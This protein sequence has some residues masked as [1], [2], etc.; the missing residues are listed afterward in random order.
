MLLSRDT[1]PKN[2]VYYLGA[3]ILKLLQAHDVKEYAFLDL[4]QECKDTTGSSYNLFSLAITWLF[5]LGVV[6]LSKKGS[7]I[8][9]S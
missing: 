4:Y 8:A 9:C 1:N 6:S 3:Q 7:I 2:D 5:L